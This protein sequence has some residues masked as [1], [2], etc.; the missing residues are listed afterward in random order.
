M[1]VSVNLTAKS[2]QKHCSNYHEQRT[3]VRAGLAHS[4]R[5]ED[6]DTC[7]RWE[8]ARGC[9]DLAGGAKWRT[10]VC[11]CPESPRNLPAHGLGFRAPSQA[12]L[13][14]RSY[15]GFRLQSETSTHPPNIHS[16]H[17]IALTVHQ[18]SFGHSSTAMPGAAQSAS[19]ADTGLD[20]TSHITMFPAARSATAA[21]S[22]EHLMMGPFRA[23]GRSSLASGP[24]RPLRQGS[25][26]HPTGHTTASR[27]ASRSH[28]SQ[29][30]G[31]SETAF[32]TRCTPASH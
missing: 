1:E 27:H 2:H 9:D 30:F 29:V 5:T 24:A 28:P 26:H 12:C 8:S 18:Q 25:Y 11:L 14:F 31:R 22:L 4:P 19:A 17:P 10:G 20:R 32:G 7:S 23:G 6:W 21:R 16:L 3:L 15:S 13:P